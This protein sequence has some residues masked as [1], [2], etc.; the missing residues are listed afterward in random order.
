MGH[1]FAHFLV[2]LFSICFI[3]T[4]SAQRATASASKAPVP[5]V[6]RLSL[7]PQELAGGFW[8]TDHDFTPTLQITNVLTVAPLTV[9]PVIYMEDGTPYSLGPFNLAISGVLALD[10]RAKLEEA[11]PEIAAHVSEYGRRAH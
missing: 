10:L 9:T 7:A 2:A 1:R 3:S 5:G 6:S 11:P 4:A 8:R